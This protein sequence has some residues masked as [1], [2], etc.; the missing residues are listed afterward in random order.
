LNALQEARIPSPSYVLDTGRGLLLVWLHEMIPAAAA[1][2]WAAVEK[3]IVAAL[4]DFGADRKATDVARVFR[5]VFSANSKAVPARRPV[6][7][8][9]CL[10]APT[11][12]YR[13]VFDPLADAVL[14]FTRAQLHALR[15]EKA[16]RPAKGENR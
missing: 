4:A 15:A 13:Y 10:G 11:K 9:W 2:R 5:V 12:P 6:G 8:I 1:S 3:C 14:P 16:S 7:M